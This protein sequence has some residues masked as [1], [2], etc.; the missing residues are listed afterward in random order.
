MRVAVIGSRGF[1]DEELLN[2]SLACL[3]ISEIISGGAKGADELAEKYAKLNSI[4]ILIIKPN[5]SLGRHAGLLRNTQI[6]EACDML[7][8][9]WDGQSK[10]TLDSLK[11]AE[12]SAKQIKIVYFNDLCSRG[13]S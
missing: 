2:E 4:P 6:V 11:K 3:D 5:W 12:K 10:G 8:A 9:F 7:V 1:F 13:N